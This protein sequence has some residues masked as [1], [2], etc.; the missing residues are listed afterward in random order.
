MEWRRADS[1][2]KE[3]GHCCSNPDSDG[4]NNCAV[5]LGGRAKFLL[6]EYKAGMIRPLFS[7]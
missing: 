6:V 1:E 3:T 7:V 2:V 5:S 4:L